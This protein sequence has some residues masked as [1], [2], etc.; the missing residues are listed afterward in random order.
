MYNP[1]NLRNNLLKI[2][3]QSVAQFSLSEDFP[4]DFHNDHRRM[5]MHTGDR[6]VILVLCNGLDLHTIVGRV[7]DAVVERGQAATQFGCV[8][9]LGKQQTWITIYRIV[10]NA[11]KDVKSLSRILNTTSWRT[12]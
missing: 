8:D 5:Y 2:D 3:P 4:G 1:M 10:R 11:P 9:D 7:V 12:L 6:P